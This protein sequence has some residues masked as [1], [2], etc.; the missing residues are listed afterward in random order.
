MQTTNPYLGNDILIRDLSSPALAKSWLTSET[1]GL[2]QVLSM[3]NCIKA[4]MVLAV[5]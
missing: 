2:A 1:I 4:E 5:S 3:E